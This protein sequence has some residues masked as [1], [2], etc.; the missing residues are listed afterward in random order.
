MD[1]TTID[2]TKNKY[3]INIGGYIDLINYKNDIEKYA[4][5]YATISREILTSINQRVKRAYI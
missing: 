4:K 1:S 3:K 5:K 2:I